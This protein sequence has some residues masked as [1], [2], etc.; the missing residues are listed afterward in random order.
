MLPIYVRLLVT[1]SGPCILR[2]DRPLQPWA[3]GHQA[4]AFW[5]HDYDRGHHY[6]DTESDYF[7][8]LQNRDARHGV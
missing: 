8:S 1:L 4:A 5:P 3:N 2:S 6:L 7:P